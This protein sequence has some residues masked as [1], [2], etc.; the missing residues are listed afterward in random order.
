[1]DIVLTTAEL[2]ELIAQH[3]QEFDAIALDPTAKVGWQFDELLK[4]GGP[5]QEGDSLEQVFARLRV[6][7][8]DSHP[9][10]T[11]STTSATSNNYLNQVL[12][13]LFKD[14]AGLEVAESSITETLRKNKKGFGVVSRDQE[15][16]YLDEASGQKFVGARVY[17]FKNIQNLIRQL[18]TA[19][20]TPYEY[21]E[22]MACPGGCFNGGGQLRKKDASLD[23]LREEYER[24]SQKHL[25]CRYFYQNLTAAGLARAIFEGSTPLATRQSIEYNIQP[26]QASDNPV[27][28]KW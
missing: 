10:Y 4:A 24:L 8:L 14:R 6:F 19:S 25:T 20:K 5:L 1:M 13:R 21:I 23:G 3:R 12:M 22:L 28:M 7:S 18:K 26:L 9:L 2:L 27:Q 11:N 16:E 15:V 17:G